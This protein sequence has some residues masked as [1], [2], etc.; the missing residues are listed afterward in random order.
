MTRERGCGMVPIAKKLMSKKICSI[1]SEGGVLEEGKEI[2]WNEIG[3]LL[4]KRACLYPLSK[5]IGKGRDK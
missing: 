2:A 5:V 1:E 3:S 4:V